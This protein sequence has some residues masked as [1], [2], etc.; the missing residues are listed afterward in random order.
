MFNIIFNYARNPELRR[1]L[2]SL[3][4]LLYFVEISHGVLVNMILFIFRFVSFWRR[5]RQ[6]LLH[7]ARPALSQVFA[8]LLYSIY[9]VSR[10]C[11]DLSLKL[12]YLIPETKSSHKSFLPKLVTKA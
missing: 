8:R 12:K 10:L 5:G 11:N 9:Y 3:L 7:H 6:T 1:G 2:V 4:F